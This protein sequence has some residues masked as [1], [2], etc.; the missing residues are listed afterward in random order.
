M[1][2]DTETDVR[3]APII[4][5][6]WYRQVL[7]QYPTGVCVVTGRSPEGETIAMVSTL[8]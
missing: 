4:D 8:R 3:P 2:Q 7:G 6:T 5:P 1:S